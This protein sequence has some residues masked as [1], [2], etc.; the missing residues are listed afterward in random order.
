MAFYA[1]PGV[2][3]PILSNEFNVYPPHLFSDFSHSSLSFANVTAFSTI[4]FQSFNCQDVQISI[5]NIR[6][7]PFHPNISFCTKQPELIV[8]K[9]EALPQ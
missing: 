5:F 3:H 7:Y 6:R 4:F 1:T 2:G 8:A 9:V